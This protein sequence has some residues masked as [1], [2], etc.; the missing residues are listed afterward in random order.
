MKDHQVKK[1]F[2][3]IAFSYDFQNSFLSLRRD[4]YWRRAL[5]RCIISR[6]EALILDMATGTAEVAIEI[7]RHHPG[8]KV[9]G[10]DF[11]PKMLAIGKEKVSSRNLDS[12]I[13]LSLG[14]GRQLPVKSGCFDAATIA[15]GIRNI[16]EREFFQQVFKEDFLLV[17]IIASDPIRHRRAMARDRTDD[18]KNIS[19]IRKRDEREVS[20]G[21]EKVISSA[22]VVIENNNSLDN[23]CNQMK[24][25]LLDLQKR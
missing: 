11:S 13:R 10:V 9:V 20:W 7:C 23:F 18:S 24:E 2:E 12:R 19:D 22:D 8:A 6:E 14:D 5:A 16:E 25:F 1:M 17:A 21:I 15:F 3:T 4:V